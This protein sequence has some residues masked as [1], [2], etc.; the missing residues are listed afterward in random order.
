MSALQIIKSEHRNLY[1]VL[2]V[3]RSV[4]F[5]MRDGQSFD[6]ALLAAIIDYIDAFPE[7]FHHPK[8]NEYLFK[9]LR[10]VCSV[11]ETTLAELEKE[12]HE[13]PEEIA[14]LRAALAE[15]DAN[16]AG[17]P[18]RFAEMLIVYAEM[19]MGHMHKEESIILPLAAKE[20]SPEDWGALDAA[21]ADNRDPLFSEDAREEMRSLYSRIVA[22]APAPWGVGG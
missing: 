3:L 17:A 2:H 7:R 5:A 12:H 18:A 16:V 19:S 21:F 6:T 15:I 4:G 9:A 8:E 22:L 11:A 1:R 13:G 20:L 10:R 14:R